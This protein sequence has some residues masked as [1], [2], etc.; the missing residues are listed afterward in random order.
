MAEEAVAAFMV[1]VVA[2]FMVAV[3]AAFTVASQAADTTAAVTAATTVDLAH[4]VEVRASP[5]AAAPLGACVED[6]SRAEVPAHPEPGPGK[7]AEV[8]V[9]PRPAGILSDPGMVRAWRDREAD[10]LAGLAAD[11]VLAMRVEDQA[12]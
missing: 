3:G 1:A 11:R 8:L 12:I 4:T 10:R 2:A 6:R 5:V 9:V 7:D